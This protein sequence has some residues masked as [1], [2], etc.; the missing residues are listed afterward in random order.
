MV[1][2]ERECVLSCVVVNVCIYIYI[3]IYGYLNICSVFV[4]YS[5]VLGVCVGVF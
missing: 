1:V 3:Y 2:Q 5:A 4:L